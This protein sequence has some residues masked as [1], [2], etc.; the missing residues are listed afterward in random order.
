LAGWTEA[1]LGHAVKTKSRRTRL[2]KAEGTHST[3]AVNERAGIYIHSKDLLD[4]HNPFTLLWTL[5]NNHLPERRE[6]IWAKQL[7]ERVTFSEI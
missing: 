6:L 2:G 7:C 1:F 5:S 3:E 4:V